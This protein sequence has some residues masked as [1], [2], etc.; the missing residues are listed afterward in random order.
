MAAMKMRWL[1]LALA[2]VLTAYASILLIE[3]PFLASL[4]TGQTANVPLG[5]FGSFYAS[6]QAAANGLDPFD[7]Y[8]LTMDAALGRQGAAVNLNAPLSV[9]IFQVLTLFDPASAR[10]GWFVATLAAFVVLAVGLVLAYP[11]RR[12][13][14][15]IVWPFAMAAFW[16]TL[17]LGQVYAFL[18]LLATG[19]WLLVGRRPALAGVLIGFVVAFK[20]NF[21]VWP[22]LLWLAGERRASGVAAAAAALWCLLPVALYGPNIYVQ[23][24]AA[25]RSSAINTQVANGSLGGLATRLGAPATVGVLIMGSGLLAMAAWVWRRRTSASTTSAMAMTGALLCSPLAWVG[26]SLFLLPIFANRRPSFALGLAGTLLCIP[27]LPLQEWSDASTLVR[28]T[29]GSAYTVAWLLLVFAIAR[30]S[31]TA[32]DPAVTPAW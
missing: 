1:R 16:E 6:G 24:F 22:V 26:Y 7:V 18:A 32:D 19:A 14:L 20:P 31:R 5:D 28:A 25:V 8:P 23:W 2:C 10:L 9:P 11:T 30:D 15:Q 17:N 12:G 4:A 29:L 21:V 13:P 27:R 3:S